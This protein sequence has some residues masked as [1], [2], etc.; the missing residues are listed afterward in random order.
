MSNNGIVK[1]FN[2]QDFINEFE[3]YGRT[4]NFSYTGLRALFDSLDDIAQD[5]GQNIEMD[6]IALCCEFIE[7]H[8]DDVISNYDI[9]V[10]DMDDD[11]KIETVREYLQE[12]TYF[13]SDYELSDLDGQ[14]FLYQAF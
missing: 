12:H 1:T 11:E 13:I 8:I 9:D 5:S 14:F 2:Q 10:S 6:V 4:D 3:A 7:E